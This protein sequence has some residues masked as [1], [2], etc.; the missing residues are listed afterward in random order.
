MTVFVTRLPHPPLCPSTTEVEQHSLRRIQV[1]P[2]AKHDFLSRRLRSRRQGFSVLRRGSTA[3]SLRIH[4]RQICEV[5][6][7]GRH[8]FTELYGTDVLS[9]RMQRVPLILRRGIWTLQR[10]VVF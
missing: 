7:G 1:G 9:E 8:P 6:H 4:P 3:A 2:R 10:L 5:L